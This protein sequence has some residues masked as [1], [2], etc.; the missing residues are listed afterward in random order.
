MNISAIP[1]VLDSKW[2]NVGSRGWIFPCAHQDMLE[3]ENNKLI[4][5]LV[6]QPETQH[7]ARRSSVGFLQPCCDN[8]DTYL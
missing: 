3:K 4:A 7:R 8:R 1:S 6:N 2:A 5:L